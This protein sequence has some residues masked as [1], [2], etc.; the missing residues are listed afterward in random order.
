MDKVDHLERH[1]FVNQLQE[2]IVKF[3]EAKQGTTFAINADWGCGKSFILDLLDRQLS[4]FQDTECANDKFIIFHYNCWHYDFY[5]E[6]AIAIVAAIQDEI[7]KYERIFPQI[8]DNARK[9]ARSFIQL[10][11]KL[12]SSAFAPAI[13]KKYSYFFA[14]WETLRN[15]FFQKNKSEEDSVCFDPYLQFRTALAETKQVL[16][17]LSQERQ[18]VL[19]VDELDR[20]L[21]EYAIKVLERLHHLFDENSNIIVVIATDSNQ[22]N[23]TVQQTFG[24]DGENAQNLCRNYLKK[25]IH[26]SVFLDNGLISE[27]FWQN[28]SELIQKYHLGKSDIDLCQLTVTKLFVNLPP[29]I[30]EQ[31]LEHLNLV[32]NLVFK[33]SA[34]PVIL[35]F[36]LIYEAITAQFD[37][38]GLQVN[39]FE[40]LKDANKPEVANQY[41]SYFPRFWSF[42][43]EYMSKARREA[44]FLKPLIHTADEYPTRAVAVYLLCNLSDVSDEKCL[45]QYY[46]LDFDT[47]QLKA[48][49]SSA[50]R[51]HR[52]AQIIQ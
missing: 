47:E 45:K 9:L 2:I 17:A 31:A 44:P 10:S 26:F 5:D 21:P 14:F 15:A 20:C 34:T 51:Y 37:H 35:L 16:S 12:F 3:S 25:F 49:L 4:V 6:P 38:V 33:D 8:S 40:W 41:K 32:H 23:R 1:I 48:L 36:E 13:P 11:I 27:N 43:S 24:F 29:R 42:L 19:L 39:S 46:N 52:F 22:L 7:T 18:V 30:C 28:H 50:K